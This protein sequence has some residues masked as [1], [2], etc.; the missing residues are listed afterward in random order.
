MKVRPKWATL[1]NAEEVMKILKF[2]AQRL[3]ISGGRRHQISNATDAS[4][5]Q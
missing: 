5:G 1:A 2:F 4:N 3:P